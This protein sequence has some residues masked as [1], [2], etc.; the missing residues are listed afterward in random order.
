MDKGGNVQEKNPTWNLR[1]VAYNGYGDVRDL[2]VEI[3]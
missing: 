3:D 2:T 1:G